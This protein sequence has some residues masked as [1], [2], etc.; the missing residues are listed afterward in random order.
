MARPVHYQFAQ[1]PVFQWRTYDRNT[2]TFSAHPIIP[3]E[4]F[5]LGN[6]YA[7]DYYKTDQPAPPVFDNMSE[8]PPQGEAPESHATTKSDAPERIAQTAKS[9][10]SAP[11]AKDRGTGR[12]MR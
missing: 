8:L 10:G 9:E 6:P 4:R 3:P 2:L 12:K 5:Y 1:L 11:L 7:D